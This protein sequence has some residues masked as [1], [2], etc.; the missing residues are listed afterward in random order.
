MSQNPESKIKQENMVQELKEELRRDREKTVSCF[1]NWEPDIVAKEK[2]HHHHEKHPNLG[3]HVHDGH[4]H[5]DH[6]HD[7]RFEYKT[8][9]RLR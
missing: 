6:H 4:H 8:T 9:A 3:D 7:E 5:A 1:A 2:G